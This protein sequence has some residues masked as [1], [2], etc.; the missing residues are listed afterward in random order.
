MK[1]NKK[2]LCLFH[3]AKVQNAI[4]FIQK[5]SNL[6]I[7][8]GQPL[9]IGFSGGKDSQCVLKLAEL[10]KVPFIAVYNNTTIDPPENV[11][12][13][14]KYYPEVKIVN[15]KS[16]FFSECV[17]QNMLPRIG[18]RWC[19]KVFKESKGYGFIITGVRADESATRSKYHRLSF[20][21]GDAYS[22]RKMRKNRK[23]MAYPI[24]DWSE[25]DVWQFIDDYDLP[26][27]PCYELSG[28]VGCLFCP[29]APTRYRL[30]I[31]DR[32]PRYYRLMLRTISQMMSNGYMKNEPFSTPE[33]VY[34]WWCSKMSV[35]EYLLRL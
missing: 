15:P 1:K 35:D 25:G 20:K 24:L 31:R 8:M 30:L 5:V 4:D 22:D 2:Q 10:A 3:D 19:C 23:V 11:R 6:A 7:K 17:K 21:N 28:R 27:N 13:I 34:E 14:R 32:Y 29:F 26:I 33:E 12:F 16:N 18:A 9:F